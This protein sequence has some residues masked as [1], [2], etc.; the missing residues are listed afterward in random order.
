MKS[1]QGVDEHFF[2]IILVFGSDAAGTGCGTFPHR[3]DKMANFWRA[4]RVTLPSCYG[5]WQVGVA[6]EEIG[7]EAVD[8]LRTLEEIAAYRRGE[9]SPWT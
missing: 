2:E 4:E 1:R 3:R 8:N 6:V 9:R 5:R 7:A